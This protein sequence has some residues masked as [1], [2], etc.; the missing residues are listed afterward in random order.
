MVA[1]LVFGIVTS[2][3]SYGIDE[4]VVPIANRTSKK[5]EFLAIY[6]A[7]MPGG[8]SN[9]T[10][11]ERGKDMSIN[12]VFYIG[13]YDEK[14]I[15]NIIILDF[16][17]N[18][19]CQIISAATGAWNHG[20]WALEKG[21]TYVLA[22]DS[23]ITRIMQFDKLSIPGIKNAQKAL[24]AQKVAPK[25]MSMGELADYMNILK[26]SNAL[27]PDL[28]VRFHQKFAQPLA[29]LIVALAG[30]PLGL[31]A[32]RSRSNIGLVYSAAIVFAYYVMVSSCGAMGESGRLDPFF[33]AWLPNICIGTIG[34]IILYFKAR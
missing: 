22:G 13:N 31:L 21:R 19:L 29:C 7:E 18:N 8:T 33:A 25:D 32:R 2:L 23:D 10:Y 11:M 6:K 9:F 1:P 12:R 24:D 30:A 15:H 34:L 20:E 16:S 27:T 5:L 28:L 26:A 14:K 4:Y 17:R 3:A